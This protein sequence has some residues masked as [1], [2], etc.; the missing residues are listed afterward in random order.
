MNEP[1]RLQIGPAPDRKSVMIT[2]NEGG[3][4]LT[5]YAAGH[6]VAAIINHLAALSK[7]LASP[8]LL[9]P[10]PGDGHEGIVALRA[11]D[12][13]VGQEP[14]S[15]DVV[16]S[17]QTSLGPWQHFRLSPATARQLAQRVLQAAEESRP[18]GRA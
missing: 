17:F 11:Q 5:T 15:G 18:L 3:E 2:I 13:E 6:E 16:L 10:D 12:L 9:S 7:A 1:G 14:L 4:S 8:T